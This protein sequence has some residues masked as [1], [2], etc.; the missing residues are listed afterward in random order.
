MD[1]LQNTIIPE[2]QG[3]GL[4]SEVVITQSNLNDSTQIQQMRQLVDQGV[5]ARR[6]SRLL[7]AIGNGG[8]GELEA[9]RRERPRTS[10]PG[11]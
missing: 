9:E 3:L 2:W 1:E 4:L 8:H 5:D 6:V 10:R 7:G 11:G